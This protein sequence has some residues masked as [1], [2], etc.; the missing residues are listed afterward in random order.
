MYVVSPP[1]GLKPHRSFFTSNPSEHSMSRKKRLKL[2]SSETYICPEEE[3][4]HKLRITDLKTIYPLTHNQ[5]TFF[6]FYN[7]G[8][9]AILLHGVAG[10]GKTYIAMYSAFQE[11]LQPES[12]YKKVIVV[13]SA[14]PSRDIGYLP[15][16]EKEKVEV[17]AQ[18]YQEI[19]TELF[20]RFGD[21]AYAK[22]KEQSL[23]TFMVT[24]YVRGL[25]LDNS[26]VIVDEAQNMNDMELNS[27]MTRVGNNTKII[28]CGDFRQTDLC[29][30]T[31]L[32]GLKKFMAIANHMPT[33]RHVEFDVEDIVRSALVKEYILARLMY[34]DMMIA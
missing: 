13:R 25:T 33:F 22:L 19:C 30:R 32:S 7:K 34:E 20:P 15:G 23:I 21:K 1:V 28:F 3:S 16:T 12:D 8:T 5:E 9:K 18:P 10:T 11:I 14:V 17:Y 31:D 24:S 29:K 26:I 27:I 4:K 6:N 2:V